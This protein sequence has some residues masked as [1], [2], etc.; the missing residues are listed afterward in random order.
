M[1]E[2]K[3]FKN[4]ED[5]ISKIRSGNPETPRLIKDCID[6]IKRFNKLP[7]SDLFE[8]QQVTNDKICSLCD[9]SGIT[10]ESVLKKIDLPKC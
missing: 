6:C 8:Y 10:Y 2:N 5:K 9:A 7:E 1:N 3:I 4:Y